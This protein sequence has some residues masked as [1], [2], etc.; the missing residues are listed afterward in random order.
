MLRRTT[1][2]MVAESAVQVS[3]AHAGNHDV[4]RIESRIGVEAVYWRNGQGS[5]LLWWK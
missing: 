3:A 4:P 5:A 2:G 1:A